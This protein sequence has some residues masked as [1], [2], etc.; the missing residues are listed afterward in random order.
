MRYQLW[1][2]ETL[3]SWAWDPQIYN[4]AAGNSLYGLAARDYAPWPA[5]LK[6]ATARMEAMP[7]LLAEARR[8]L[9]PARVPAI[10]A[11]TVAK[12]NGGVVEIAET[13]L[14]PHVDTLGAADRARFEHALAALKVAV[15]AHQTWLDT[16]LV[17]NAKGDFRLGPA[18]YDQ[19]MRFA[20]MSS[21]TRPELKARAEKTV[22]DV[23]AQMYGYA[24]QVLAG[25]VGAPPLPDAP[26][27][28]QQQAGIEA[29]LA[30]TYAKRPTR[31]GLMPAAKAALDDE[32]AFRP[33][34][35]SG[36]HARCAGDGDHHAQIPSGHRHRL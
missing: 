5:R 2:I 33:H 19:K 36:H 3:R 9:V 32:T 28:A 27:A 30:L 10:F 23:R 15:A 13:M 16:V 21:L 29:A 1:Q 12:Q 26:R 11:S 31:E 18:L 35:R 20:M 6:A 7:A 14:A 34:A 22:S 4:D 24:R 8:Q 17:P 25:R